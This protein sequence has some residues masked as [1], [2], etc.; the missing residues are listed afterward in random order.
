MKA[1]ALDSS[2]EATPLFRLSLETRTVIVR[3]LGGFGRL[4]WLE[5]S[6]IP[7]DLSIRLYPTCYLMIKRIPCLVLS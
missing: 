4:S 5:S 3:V 1:R 6:E 7:I 2:E